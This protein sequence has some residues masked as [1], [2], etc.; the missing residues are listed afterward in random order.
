[1]AP[2]HAL[3]GLLPANTTEDYPPPPK[4]GA[5][6]YT[7]FFSEFFAQRRPQYLDSETGRLKINELARD[8]GKAWGDLPYAEVQRYTEA[9]KKDRDAAQDAY[10][11]WFVALTPEQKRAVQ[12]D[13]KKPL[14]VPG[15]REAFK[16]RLDDAPGNPGRPI[17]PFFLFLREAT[18]KIAQEPEAKSLEQEGAANG[19]PRMELR[20]YIGKRA[21][22]LWNQLSE[23]EKDEY[24]SRNR[25]MREKYDA[26]KKEYEEKAK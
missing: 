1:M 17:G 7:L 15:G 20:R 12:A 8:C 18:P 22:E 26:W 5:S 3:P 4:R 13:R 14:L 11:K 9:S 16:R 2:A 24:K 23:A 21:G 10:E 19:K 6:A 25:E